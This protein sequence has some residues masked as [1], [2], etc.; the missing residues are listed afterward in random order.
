MAEDGS[1]SVK[2]MMN[3]LL[4]HVDK[5]E[6]LANLARLLFV[7]KANAVIVRDGGI[8]IGIVTSKDI[9]KGIIK[10]DRSPHSIKAD[11]IMSSPIITVDHL[12]GPDNVRDVMLNSKI[13]KIPVKKDL[14]IIGLVIQT[15]IIRNMEFF[16]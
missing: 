9:L 3:G 8:P 10:L 1:I 14:D 13:N 11:E 12:D 2:N 6:N 16:R 7:D 15:D 5:S 4:L